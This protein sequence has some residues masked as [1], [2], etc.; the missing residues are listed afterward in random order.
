MSLKGSTLFLSPL[1]IPQVTTIDLDKPLMPLAGRKGGKR[2]LVLRERHPMGAA[3]I[4]SSLNCAFKCFMYESAGEHRRWL[5]LKA[6][7]GTRQEGPPDKDPQQ[8]RLCVRLP[9]AGTGEDVWEKGIGLT[10]PRLGSV[11]RRP[12]RVTMCPVQV[13]ELASICLP[14]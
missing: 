9:Q 1:P 2:Q 10:F 5:R 12:Q 4:P 6:F 7:A 13:R 3:F 14:H 11:Q 8:Q